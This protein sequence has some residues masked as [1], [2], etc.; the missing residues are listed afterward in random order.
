MGTKYLL[1]SNTVI[2]L[3]SNSFPESTSEK[4]QS[5]IDAD[6]YFL[7][8]ITRMEVLGFNGNQD[9]MELATEFM[10]DSI[11]IGLEEAIILRTIALRKQQKIKLPDAIIAATALVHRLTLVTRNL[12][13]FKNISGLDLINPDE[14]TAA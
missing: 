13:D 5:I 2:Y 10:S 7:S 11:I 3:L 14:L 12:D 8:V 6:D 1:D 9:E 4:I